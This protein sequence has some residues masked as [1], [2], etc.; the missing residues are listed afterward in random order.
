MEPMNVFL[1]THRQEFKS[2][3]DEICDISSDRATSAIPPSYATPITVL[4]RLPGTSR[5]GF[6][7][8][9]YLIDQAKECASLVD[10]WLDAKYDIDGTVGWTDE[11]KRFD[12]L[13]EE[14]RERAK[15][16]LTRAEQ[17][18][19]PSGVLEP[20]W[21]ELVEQME[22]KARLRENNGYNAPH[23]PT[24]GESNS[25][26]VNSSTSSLAEGY[27]HRNAILHPRDAGGAHYSSKG[28][29]GPMATSPHSP[30]SP[31]E[32][33]SSEMDSETTNTPPGSSS[34]IW[35]PL[36]SPRMEDHPA[37]NSEIDELGIENS[38]D[39]LGSSIYNLAPVKSKRDSDATAKAIPVSTPARSSYG[40]RS[41]HGSKSSQS[42]KGHQKGP[43]SSYGLRH[44]SEREDIS[45]SVNK[46]KSVTPSSSRDGAPSERPAKSLYRLNAAGSSQQ[47]GDSSASLG[48]RSPSSRDG[49][50][51]L[52]NSVFGGVFRK[53]ARERDKEREREE[54]Y[55]SR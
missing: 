5:E 50:G 14:S 32:A 16:C 39:V 2:F 38:S 17:A 55:L 37:P 27:F 42:S 23:T 53:R 9:P 13:C 18:E 28:C 35:D 12:E 8:L 46:S 30:L 25:H 24:A 33:T 26:T 7:S 11:L 51:G 49:K 10:V 43:R 1:T 6:P 41:S 34:G 54:G 31:D 52:S 21:E 19:R 45:K 47:A 4:S 3:V 22:R 36:Q 44:S 29:N 48:R 20:K 15:Q 40:S